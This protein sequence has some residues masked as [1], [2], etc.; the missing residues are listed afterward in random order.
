MNFQQAY[1]RFI[2]E[3]EF[4][5]GINMAI[6]IFLFLKWLSANNIKIDD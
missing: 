4:P 6:A 5:R 3:Q 2:K 1:D